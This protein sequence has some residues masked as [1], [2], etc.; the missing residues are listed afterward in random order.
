MTP[1]LLGAGVAVVLSLAACDDRGDGRDAAPTSEPSSPLAA[2]GGE[3]GALEAD[4]GDDG[5]DADESVDEQLFGTIPA[6]E[7]E[8]A[9]LDGGGP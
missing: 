7:L 5:G 2:D 6:D 9:G 8:D 4:A 3:D 1:R